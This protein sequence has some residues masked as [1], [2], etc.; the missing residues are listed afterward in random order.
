MYVSVYVR[1]MQEEFAFYRL[2]LTLEDLSGIH[3][4]SLMYCLHCIVRDLHSGVLCTPCVFRDL[5]SGALCTLC[6]FRDLHNGALCTLCVF[7]DLHSGALC[8]SL[9]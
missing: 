1:I 5:H 6:V 9:R 2:Y 4:K 7:R 3:C 8:C